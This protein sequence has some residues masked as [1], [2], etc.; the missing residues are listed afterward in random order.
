MVSVV[1]L[2][3]MKP[4]CSWEIDH[5]PQA[6]KDQSFVDL[7][8][9]RDEFDPPIVGTLGR[10]DASYFCLKRGTMMLFLQSSGI[11]LSIVTLLKNR[12]SKLTPKP[13]NTFQVLI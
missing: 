1:E 13:L 4:H 9:V 12:I 6:S 3:D 7:N 2:S 11:I 10:S 5:L 8:R